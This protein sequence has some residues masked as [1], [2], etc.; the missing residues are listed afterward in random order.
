MKKTANTALTPAVHH[1]TSP[2]FSE[3][4]YL[5]VDS[6]SKFHHVEATIGEVHFQRRF[7]QAVR[8][9]CGRRGATA[10]LWSVHTTWLQ[11][12]QLLLRLLLGVGIR[13]SLMSVNIKNDSP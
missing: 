3:I 9:P 10:A 13:H 5:H 11:L 1:E 12:L 8:A 7:I 4:P 2:Q 6:I